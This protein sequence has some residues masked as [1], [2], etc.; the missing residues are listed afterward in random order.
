MKRHIR[1]TQTA[2]YTKVSCALKDGRVLTYWYYMKIGSKWYAF[3]IRDAAKALNHEVPK[4][5]EDDPLA[6]LVNV[7]KWCLAANAQD[8]IRSLYA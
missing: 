8:T 6:S 1:F 5:Y 4:L 2:G 3:D 7:M